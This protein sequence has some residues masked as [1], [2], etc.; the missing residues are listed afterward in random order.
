[1]LQDAIFLSTAVAFFALSWALVS[2]AAR[3]ELGGKKDRES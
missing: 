1:M 2:F 3:L